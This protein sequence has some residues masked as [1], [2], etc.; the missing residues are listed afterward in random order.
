LD[1][2]NFEWLPKAAVYCGAFV[3]A[4]SVA[5]GILSRGRGNHARLKIIALL[6]AIL[7]LA[8]LAARAW[9]HTAAVFGWADSL[10]FE[11]LRLIAVESRW[12]QRW[13]LQAAFAIVA[14]AAALVPL[15]RRK[16]P[17]PFAHGGSPITEDR[18][19]TSS[20]V[21]GVVRASASSSNGRS[22]VFAVA[23][24]AVILSI[25]LLGHAAGSPYRY[26]LHVTHLAAG[27]LWLGSLAVLV[28]LRQGMPFAL[29]QRFSP[30][31]LAFAAIVFLSGAG[32]AALYIGDVENLVASQ[33]GRLLLLKVA[34]VFLV[35]IC[36]RLNWLRV[37]AGVIPAGH[38]MLAEAAAALAVI[39]LTS[40]LTETEHP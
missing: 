3:A 17:A 16:R 5:I 37:Q 9:F 14:F 2:L 18:E 35:V 21:T 24:A 8:G 7:M 25:P 32:A 28:A 10:S 30:L 23:V 26:V 34:L 6:S 12:G 20:G 38:V 11:N 1:E 4:G 27:A 19:Q 31:A 39:V 29:V 22:T 36:G 13:Q 15:I 33:Y 40:I